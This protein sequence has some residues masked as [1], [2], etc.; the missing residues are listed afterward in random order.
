MSTNYET[1]FDIAFNK[2]IAVGSSQSS[3]RELLENIYISVQNILLI[4]RFVPCH[5]LVD[6]RAGYDNSG[7]NLGKNE[8]SS[9]KELLESEV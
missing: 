7:Q 5:G 6:L 2:F 8:Q 9:K 1:D 3:E 4:H